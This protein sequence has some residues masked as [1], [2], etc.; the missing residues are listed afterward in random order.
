[1]LL[2]SQIERQNGIG[3][4]S[5]SEGNLGIKLKYNKYTIW[6][7]INIYVLGIMLHSVL[8]VLLI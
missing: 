3:I 1:M 7:F 6:N 5:E 4:C 2:I 8:L